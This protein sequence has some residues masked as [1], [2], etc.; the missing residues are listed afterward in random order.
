MHRMN[1]KYEQYFALVLHF[2]GDPQWMINHLPTF[3]F[4]Y[5]ISHDQ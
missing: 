3:A 1:K 5:E 4:I 2:Q